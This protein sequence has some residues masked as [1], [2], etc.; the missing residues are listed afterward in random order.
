MSKLLSTFYSPC[1]SHLQGRYRQS[2]RTGYCNLD[3]DVIFARQSS[4][5]MSSRASKMLPCLSPRFT[6][7]STDHALMVSM[8]TSS[9][10]I[11]RPKR[12]LKIGMPI[13]LLRSA[14]ASNGLAEAC[15]PLSPTLG[16]DFKPRS[17]HLAR[18][19]P[20]RESAGA[21]AGSVGPSNLPRKSAHDKADA[22][23]STE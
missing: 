10:S 3:K 18:T 20:R 8:G 12:S 23:H 22:S 19:C 6:C 7:G 14:K 9:S 2:T 13:Q 21:S 5:S 16:S 15:T 4:A 11:K 17:F 1:A